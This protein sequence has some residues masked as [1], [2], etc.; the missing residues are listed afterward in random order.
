MRGCRLQLLE[1]NQVLDLIL[2]RASVEASTWVFTNTE[3]VYSKVARLH[4]KLVY[5][6]SQ[7]AI[8]SHTWIRDEPGDV[9]FQGWAEREENERG[10][11][12]IAR[13]C[14]AAAQDHSMVLGWMDTVCINKESSSELDESIRS[15]LKWY[16]NS[17]ACVVYLSETNT[18]ADMHTDT[19]FTRGWTLQ[20]LLAPP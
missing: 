13:F 9:V 1:R 3:G 5:A 8:L 17:W 6:A 2:R 18:I 7:Y 14:R 16:R 10:Y 19:W 4:T 15:M 11:A 12:K 20:E